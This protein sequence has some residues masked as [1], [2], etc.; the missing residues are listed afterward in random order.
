MA[1]AVSGRSAVM[2]VVIYPLLVLCFL[3]PSRN[4]HL[5]SHTHAAIWIPKR[6]GRTCGSFGFFIHFD[7][8]MP[9]VRDPLFH[10]TWGIPG[11][12]IGK[13]FFGFASEP[14]IFL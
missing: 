9:F 4:Q 8:I 10:F 1:S 2:V 5:H 6:P 7:E 11:V 12:V 3:L 13:G 14:P